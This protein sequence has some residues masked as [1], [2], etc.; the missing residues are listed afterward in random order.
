MMV[1]D[2]PHVIVTALII[3]AVL[4]LLPRMAA[5]SALPSGRQ[6]LVQFLVLFV[7]LFILNLAWPYGTGA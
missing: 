5:F 4:W 2:L 1:I 7:I 6:R 3:W